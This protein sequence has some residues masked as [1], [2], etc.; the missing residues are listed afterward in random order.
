[1]RIFGSAMLAT[2]FEA[3]RRSACHAYDV[4]CVASS[5]EA[6]DAGPAPETSASAETSTREDRNVSGPAPL[7]PNQNPYRHLQ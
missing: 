2:A 7:T 5:L 1:M 4:A 3:R 6:A